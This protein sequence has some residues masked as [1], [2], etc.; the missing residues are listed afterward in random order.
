LIRDEIAKEQKVSTKIKC[1]VLDKITVENY[2]TDL[3]VQIK[4]YLEKLKNYYINVENTARTKYDGIALKMQ[5]TEEDKQGFVKLRED[6]ENIALANM[7]KNANDISGEKCLEKDGALIQQ[8]DPVY[9][10][11]VESK[12]GR[13]H[14]FAPRKNFFG[15]LISTFIFNIGV[16]WFMSLTLMIT[17][18][19]D[20]FKKVLDFFGNIQF[21]RKSA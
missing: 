4:K 3:V 19:F 10:D 6:Y 14:F 5:K 20:V 7:V 21:K 11:P 15:M 16:I 9:L 12:V 1:D 18:Y 13:A 17:L 8:S 2:N